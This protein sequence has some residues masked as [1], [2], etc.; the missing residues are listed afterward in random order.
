MKQEGQMANIITACKNILSKSWVRWA[1]GYIAVV[2]SGVMLVYYWRVVYSFA[3]FPPLQAT[4]VAVLALSLAY[5]AVFCTVKF[6][7]TF[8]LKGAILIFVAGLLFVFVNPPMQAPDESAH[9]FRAYSIGHGHF[10]Y[11]QYEDYPNDADLLCNEFPANFNFFH[12]VVNGQTIAGCFTNY[13]T[14]LASEAES[15]S[16]AST[17]IQQTVPY[18]PQATGIFIASLLKADALTTLYVARLANL[19]FYSICCYVALRVVKRFRFVLF[20]FMLTPISLFLAGS[21]SSDA[22]LNGLMWLFIAICLG[23]NVSKKRM[24]VL[25]VCF[26]ILCAARMTNLLL[27]P[28]VL[29]LPLDEKNK[30]KLI[31]I[32]SACFVAMVGLTALQNAQAEWFGNYGDVPYYHDAIQPANQLKFILQYP[33]RYA[34]VLVGALYKNMFTLFEGGLFGWLDA[35]VTFT[36]YFAPFLFLL[37]AFCSVQ[38]GKQLKKKESVLLGV[39][40]VLFYGGIYTG[41]Y[42]TSTGIQLPHINGVQMR[43]LLPA[44]FC[45]FVLVS[46]LLPH[47]QPIGQEEHSVKQLAKQKNIMLYS[48]FV[49][50]VLSAVLLFQLYYVGA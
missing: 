49:F 45:I 20:A 30:K 41:M 13:Q 3:V 39:I 24:A 8:A 40:A 17:N 26:G 29:L 38:E 14:K 19:L 12:P 11:D 27:L 4:L 9:F 2:V 10:Y 16:N 31:Y 6:A 37:A 32:I 28:F 5:G 36:S 18:L 46:A 44:L 1:L 42:V 23:E 21:A 25:A 35:N 50:A 7:K 47:I 15:A 34:L 33:L 43:Y 22:V 48:G